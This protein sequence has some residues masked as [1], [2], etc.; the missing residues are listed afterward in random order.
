MNKQELIDKAVRDLGGKWPNRDECNTNKCCYAHTSSDGEVYEIYLFNCGRITKEQFQQRAKELGYG[1]EPAVKE[2]LTD[3][4]YCYESQKAIKLPP[5]GD[6]SV[7]YLAGDG[8]W[9]GC[10]IAAY[11][12]GGAIVS[13]NDGF[14][15]VYKHELR[16]NNYH[17]KKTEQERKNVVDAAQKECVNFSTNDLFRLY[18]AGFLKLP[19]QKD[20]K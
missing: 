17:A 16:P 14:T 6:K 15:L 10:E 7:S 3:D 2:S 9:I 5:V 18:D 1:A 11:Y 13:H 19:E 8:I 20:E 4:W 12:G